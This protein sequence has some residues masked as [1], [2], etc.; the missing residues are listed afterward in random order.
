VTCACASGKGCVLVDED[1]KVFATH[2]VKREGHQRIMLAL[3]RER[4]D[5][6]PLK[7]VLV[8]EL[9][10]RR[11]ERAESQRPAGRGRGEEGVEREK[12]YK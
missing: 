11:V 10:A 3:D 9:R 2:E 12:T 1:G 8:H 7:Q 5:G 6:R 4:H